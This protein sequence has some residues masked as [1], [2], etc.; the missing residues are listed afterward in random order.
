MKIRANSSTRPFYVPKALLAS[1]SPTLARHCASGHP[2][3]TNLESLQT[4]IAWLFHTPIAT[5]NQKVLA[6]AWKFGSRFKIPAF[7]NEIMRHLIQCLHDKRIDLAAVS[8]AYKGHDSLVPCDLLRK[9]FVAQICYDNS[10]LR[11]GGVWGAND[12][13][14]SGLSSND[15]FR[16]DMA[17]A[18]C[19]GLDCLDPD[20]G[21]KSEALLL[22]E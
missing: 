5:Q 18:T 6:Q 3:L 10:D 11:L 9:A 15:D 22:P 16:E 21:A 17:S 20:V 8:E 12:F 13:K 19:V 4:F 14:A 1:V 2:A 7:Q